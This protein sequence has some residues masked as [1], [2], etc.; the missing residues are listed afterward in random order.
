MILYVFFDGLLRDLVSHSPY[1]VT[2]CPKS[3]TP[4]F[5]LYPSNP[6]KISLADLPLN[7]A[8]LRPSNLWVGILKICAPGLPRFPW[9]LSQSHRLPL[10]AKT[11]AGQTLEDPPEVSIGGIRVLTPN[12]SSSRRQRDSFD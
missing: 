8:Q 1:R 11:S 4:Q 7:L 10:S 2:I 6:G 5:T 9:L 3:T 12:G